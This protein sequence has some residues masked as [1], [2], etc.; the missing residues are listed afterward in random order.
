MAKL[1]LESPLA[2]QFDAEFREYV[3]ASI[4]YAEIQEPYEA[5]DFE[6]EMRWI[7]RWLLKNC[8]AKPHVTESW[9]KDL[10]EGKVKEIK[11]AK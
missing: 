7:K 1:Y 11:R 4:R 6:D 5:L 9:E 2:H 3:N 10:R 8:Y